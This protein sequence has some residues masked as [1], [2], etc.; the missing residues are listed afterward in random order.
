M[1]E[2]LVAVS[3]T[4]VGFLGLSW[5]WTGQELMDFMDAIDKWEADSAQNQTD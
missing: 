4:V 2:T 5:Y 1:I 3:F